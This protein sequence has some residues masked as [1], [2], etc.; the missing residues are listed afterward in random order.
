VGRPNTNLKF[1]IWDLSDTPAAPSPLPLD[2]WGQH[3]HDYPDPAFV[4]AILGSIRHGLR[5]GYNGPLRESGRMMSR[6]LPMDEASLAHVR[7]EVNKRLQSGKIRRWTGPHT[8]CSSPIGTVSKSNGKLRTIH[9]L[10]WPRSGAGS[11]VNEGISRED[12][13]LI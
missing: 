3:L 4:S 6:N 8:F 1:P 13:T 9:H 12:A 2:A 11:S 7:S 10:S 5:I